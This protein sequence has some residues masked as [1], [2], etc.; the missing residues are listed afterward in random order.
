MDSFTSYI[1][2]QT[3]EK[4]KGKGNRLTKINQAVDCE[5]FSFIIVDKQKKEGIAGDIFRLW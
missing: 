3:Y 5:A 1:L 4:V 2:R